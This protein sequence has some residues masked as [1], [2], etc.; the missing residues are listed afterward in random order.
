MNMEQEVNKEI[1]KKWIEAL[2]SGDYEQGKGQLKFGDKYCCL[3]VLCEIAVKENIIEKYEHNNKSCYGEEHQLAYLPKKIEVWV[4]LDYNPKII[5]NNNGYNKEV[6]LVS[7]NDDY[8]Y[9]F[10][11]IADVLEKQYL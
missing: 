9:S 7:L 1:I 10:K 3:G 6:S 2:R 4:G 11:E 5:I 8:G